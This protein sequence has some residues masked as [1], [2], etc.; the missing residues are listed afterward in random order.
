MIA[1]ATAISDRAVYERVAL[2]GIERVAEPDSL[3]LTRA[4]YDSIQCPY[5]E[6]MDEAAALPGLE[7]LVLLHQDLELLDDSLPRRLRRAFRDPRAGLLGVLGG[8]LSKLHCWLTPDRAFGFAI[9]PNPRPPRDPRISVGPH[10]VDG[11]DGAVLV[12]AP[13]VVRGIRFGESPPGRFHGYDVDISFRVKARGGKVICED[14][15]C[16]H[17]TTLKGDFAAQRDAGVALAR[18]WDP[19]IRPREWAAA[20][21][22]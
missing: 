9:G 8:R 6:M 15:P 11:V 17:H 7:A 14:V 21:Q 5:N 18:M 1:F 16:R 10:E 19:T 4:G 20:F 2:A 3:L 13:W 22:P 12:A